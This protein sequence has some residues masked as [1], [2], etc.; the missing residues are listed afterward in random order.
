MFQCQN[1]SEKCLIKFTFLLAW[2]SCKFFGTSVLDT[3]RD[4]GVKLAIAGIYIFES[5]VFLVQLS[6]HTLQKNELMTWTFTLISLGFK[7]K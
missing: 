5:P 7:R 1:H 3:G 2:Y 4:D 6:S